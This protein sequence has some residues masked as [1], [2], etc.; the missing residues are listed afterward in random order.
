MRLGLVDDFIPNGFHGVDAET[1]QLVVDMGF[2][3]MGLH[4]KNNPCEVTEAEVR[5][6][7]AILD[8]SGIEVVQ[9]WGPYPSII[10]PD[11]S[12]RREGIRQAQRIIELAAVAGA[13]SVGMRPTSFNPKGDWLPH[14]DNFKP[15]TED[16]LVKS[17]REI[18]IASADH[19]VQVAL[20][21]YIS[22]TLHS[23][24]AV[25]R[26]IE[27]TESPW[28]KTNLDPTNF[29]TDLQTAYNPRPLIDRLFEH[30]GPYVVTAHVK[31]VIVHDVNIVH[32]SEGRPGAG[33]FDY[34]TF[35]TRYEAEFPQQY[36]FI[37]H[38]SELDDVKAANTFLRG[39][40]AE[41]NIPILK[42]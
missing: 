12:V 19:G 11:E 15:E 10:T 16:R 18:A 40:L 20:E 35:L 26:V 27:R 2:T 3:G 21:C 34:D 5:K 4:M 13:F 31:D 42:N 8:G 14:P 28:I 7:K 22:T 39:K 25:K 6:V 17:L 38:L 23:P 29:I 41:L 1:V 37:E 33:I 24:E 9:F 32:L 36:A 30:M